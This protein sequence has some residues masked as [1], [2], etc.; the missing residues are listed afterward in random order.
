MFVIIR[1]YKFSTTVA[2]FYFLLII[3]L[4]IPRIFS[5]GW[6]HIIEPMDMRILDN[7]PIQ[8]EAVLVLRSTHAM[9]SNEITDEY[10]RNFSTDEYRAVLPIF[11]A[12][13]F[14]LV[15]SNYFW[16]SAFSDMFWWWLGALAVYALS[17]RLGHPSASAIIAGTL[18]TSSPLA[19]AQIGAGHLH[20]ASSL[21]L[22]IPMLIAWDAL[23]PARSRTASITLIAFSILISSLLYTYQWVMIPWVIYVACIH[24]S[25][26]I[27]IIRATLACL[28]YYVLSLTV[29]GFFS[30]G[31]LTLHANQ[32]D[33]ILVL[34]SRL[35]VDIGALK[36]VTTWPL[37]LFNLII[38]SF[39]VTILNLFSAY[40]PFIFFW[41]LLGLFTRNVTHILLYVFSIMFSVAQGAITDLPWVIMSGFPIIYI[42]AGSAISTLGANI[43]QH[44]QPAQLSQGGITKV[45]THSIP[46]LVLLLVMYCLYVTNIDLFGDYSFVR[47]WFSMGYKPH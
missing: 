15:T 40:S 9:L 25:R 19:V 14:T 3:S 4:S 10:R 39:Y 28:L 17:R 38:I 27:L 30:A 8:Y 42:S 24:K 5:G 21:A 41:S 46:T 35:G 32:N 20:A 44:L 13:L 7:F 29:Q 31:G 34:Q 23:L 2:F 45:I 36:D 1:N 37:R 26:R 43:S 18:V 47:S 16:G 11:T 22:P 33:P 6:R 12:A